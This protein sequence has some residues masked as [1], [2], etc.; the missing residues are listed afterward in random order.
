M[1]TFL[2]S[3]DL[4]IRWFHET[5]F[6]KSWIVNLLILFLWFL[7][8]FSIKIVGYVGILLYISLILIMNSFFE[9]QNK[10]QIWW[11]LF[12]ICENKI[13]ETIWW[14]DHLILS[15]AWYMYK[16][17]YLNCSPW[18]LPEEF[19]KKNSWNGHT[20]FL[21]HSKDQLVV[22]VARKQAWTCLQ[23][24]SYPS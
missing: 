22:V 7:L 2:E 24:A 13:S 18:N 17:F 14:A 5:C 9:Y 3:V 1:F 4:L 21:C 8:S 15:L 16:T 11:F 10:L 12:W 6:Y 19:G 20:M 23:G